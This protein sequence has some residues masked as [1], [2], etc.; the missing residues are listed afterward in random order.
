MIRLIPISPSRPAAGIV[1]I[2]LLEPHQLLPGVPFDESLK[3][4]KESA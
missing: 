1:R 4:L 2:P 3:Q